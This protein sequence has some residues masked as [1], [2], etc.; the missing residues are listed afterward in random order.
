[1][2][3][4]PEYAFTVES[5]A[6]DGADLAEVEQ[7]WEE[8]LDRLDNGD[9]YDDVADRL[10]GSTWF[11]AGEPRTVYLPDQLDDPVY[12]RLLAIGRRVRKEAR[13]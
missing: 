10:D 6:R 1:M 7:W 9:T 3:R 5:L 2:S 13:S 12:R 4:H 8:H 11:V